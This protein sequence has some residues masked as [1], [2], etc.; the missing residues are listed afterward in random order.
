M[1]GDHV[2]AGGGVVASSTLH[3]RPAIITTTI[4]HQE[5]IKSKHFN[6]DNFHF[7]PPKKSLN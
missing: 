4:T 1:F 6:R 7:P 5:L 3:V 2:L